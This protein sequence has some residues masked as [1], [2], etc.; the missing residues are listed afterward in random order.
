MVYLVPIVE[1]HGEVEALP[2]LL[3]RIAEIVSP[4]LALKVNHP[5]RVKS[6]SFLR[7]SVYFDKQIVL[8]SAKAA[9]SGGVV[10]ILLDCEDDC[11]ARVGPLLL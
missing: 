10:M 11:P 9:Q 4:G 2:A 3:H 1:G 5:I 6:G 8:A 7:D